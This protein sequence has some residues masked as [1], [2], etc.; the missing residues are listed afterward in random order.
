MSKKAI[1]YA[2]CSLILVSA[3]SFALVQLGISIQ[4]MAEN[5][6]VETK[7]QE[8]SYVVKEYKGEIAVFTDENAAPERILNIDINNMREFDRQR[9]KS[10]IV[11]KTLEELAQLEEDFS[12]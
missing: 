12:S 2:I 3:Y 7:T 9:F 4:R 1:L 6:Q 10:G 5:V 8:S 11:V